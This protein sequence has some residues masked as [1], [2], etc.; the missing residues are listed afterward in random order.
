MQV[1]RTPDELSKA[2]LDRKGPV[3]FVPT[4]GYLHEGHASLIRMAAKD[5]DA[6]KP[7]GTVVMSLFVNPTQFNDPEDLEKYPRDEE[8]DKKIAQEAGC[9][10]IFAPPLEV[11]YP[12]GLQTTRIHVPRVSERWEGEYRPGHFDG[13]ATIVAK[14]FHMVLPDYAYFGEKD[15]QQCRVIA[16]MVDDLNF[17]VYLKFGE[18]VREDDGLAMSSRNALLRPEVRLKAPALHRA[19]SQAAKAFSEGRPARICETDAAQA[20]LD[21]GFTKVDYVAIVD[22]MTLDPIDSP[23]PGARVLAAA[24]IGG[25]R[26]IDNVAV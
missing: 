7:R 1:V 10:V 20:M 6:N 24:H 8:H 5:R 13:V 25:V 23:A 12:S 15:W 26:L 2:V 21:A 18:T 14:L 19:I 11:V 17:P 16:K 9:D 22:G 4:M 3:Y